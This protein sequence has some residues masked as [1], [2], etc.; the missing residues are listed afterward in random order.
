MVFSSPIFLFVFLPLVLLGL[1]LPRLPLR[2]L[3]LLLFSILF[4]AW[5]EMTFVLLMRG[6]T[7]VNFF[8]GRWVERQAEVSGRKWAVA[9]AVT[10]NIGTLVF[11]STR[12][13]RSK[14]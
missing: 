5:G 4:Y 8:L 10:L 14:T 12:I 9:I 6:S 13:S 3:W 11:L 2:N 1:A 7:V